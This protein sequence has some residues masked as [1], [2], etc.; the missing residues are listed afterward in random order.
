MIFET[1]NTNRLT[2]ASEVLSS[3][4]PVLKNIITQFGPCEI[5]PTK[6]Y[7]QR[8]VESIIGQQLSVKAAASIRLK[9]LGLFDGKFPIPEQIVEKDIEEY[10]KAGL[11]YAKARYIQDLAVHTIEKKIKF[12]KFSE[13]PNEEI[14]KELTNVKGIGEWTAHMFL[15][16]GLGRLD[17]LP[18]G[19]L[20]IKNGI[21]KLYSLKELPTPEKIEEISDKNNWAPY[22]TVA[23]WYIWRSLDNS[24]K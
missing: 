20:G 24:P 8:L 1:A 3:N 7:Y 17:V 19:D 9:F 22:Q 16:F 11:S 4:D 14:I 15:M 5:I 23:S 12:E 13:L 21:K 2:I 18:T 6:N 10:R